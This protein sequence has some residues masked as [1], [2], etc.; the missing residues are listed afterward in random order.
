MELFWISVLGYMIGAIPFA[1]IIGKVFYHT[2]VRQKG[3]GNLGGSNTGRV[4]GGKAGV[5][6][7]TLDLLKVTLSVFLAS[8]FSGHPWSMTC[9]AVSAAIGHCY[10]IYV[11]FRGGK[12]VAALYGFLFSLWIIGDHAPLVF[13]LPLCIFLLVLAA[14]KIVSLSSIVSSVAALIYVCFAGSHISVICSAAAFT[15]LI[16]LRH[17]GNIKRMIAGNERKIHWIK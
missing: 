6:V 2:D 11:R 17:S 15:V 13:F 16:L 12:A 5:A 8:Q 7:M 1:Y 4:L 10:P 3:S 14:F 9:G